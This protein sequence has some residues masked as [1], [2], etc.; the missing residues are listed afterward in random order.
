LDYVK[1][2][3]VVEAAKELL[4]EIDAAEAQEAETELPVDSLNTP[5][6]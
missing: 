2:D 4:A 6:P 5:T 1:V 3:W